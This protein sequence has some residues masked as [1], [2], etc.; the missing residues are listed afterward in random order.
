MT[1]EII[2]EHLAPVVHAIDSEDCKRIYEFHPRLYD[3][4][5]RGEPIIHKVRIL[6][7]EGGELGPLA[8]PPQS[9]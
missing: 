2:G 3:P 7:E 6:S 5:A 8:N 1:V 9:H 4:P